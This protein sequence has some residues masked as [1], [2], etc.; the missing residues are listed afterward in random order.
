MH[1]LEGHALHPVCFTCVSL[2]SQEKF[3]PSGKKSCMN[4]RSGGGNQIDKL[5]LYYIIS[6]ADLLASLYT[7]DLPCQIQESWRLSSDWSS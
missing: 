6:R 7:I 4:L 5:V 1:P 2:L 3:P